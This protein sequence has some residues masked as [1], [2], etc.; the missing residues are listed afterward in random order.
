MNKLQEISIKYIEGQFIKPMIN[1]YSLSSKEE[2]I[3][4]L[5]CWKIISKANTIGDINSYT[6]N[7]RIVLLNIRENSYYINADTTRKGVEEF[8]KNKNN[9]WKT[10]KNSCVI[11]NK[12]D[13]ETIK[14]FYMYRKNGC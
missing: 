3:D 4:L 12:L 9:P 13:S 5:K 2:L 6:K 14:G 11:T 1:E 10:P 8:L 7:K